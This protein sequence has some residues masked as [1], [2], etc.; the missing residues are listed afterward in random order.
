MK[1]PLNR[2][3]S[4]VLSVLLLSITTI[5]VSCTFGI[6]PAFNQNLNK[7]QV[8]ITLGS[9]SPATENGRAIIRGNGFLYIQ[10][11]L[12]ASKAVLYGPYQFTSGKTLTI[13]DIP[14]GSYSNMLILVTPDALPSSF[15]SLVPSDISASLVRSALQTSLGSLQNTLSGMS[16]GIVPNVTITEGTTTAV[17]ATLM[18]A[19]VLS[20]DS[21]GKVSLTGKAG[22]VNRFFIS[23]P[24][25]KASFGGAA[26]SASTILGCTVT[27]TASSTVTVSAF[28]LFDSSGKQIS[29]DTTSTQLA[30]GGTDPYNATWAGRRPAVS[31]YR[32]YG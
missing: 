19:T 10:T 5:A 12:T 15:T 7:T 20:P 26:A 9:A 13:L 32:I 29:L 31:V 18:P 4:L 14:A 2:L 6:L 16:F 25:L 24:N 28:G 8:S 30:A 1:H 11:E 22:A 21:S 3:W 27:N 23:Y 17:S